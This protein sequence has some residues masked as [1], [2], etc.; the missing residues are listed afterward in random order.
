MPANCLRAQ[1]ISIISDFSH[2]WDVKLDF[3][4]SWVWT[5]GDPTPLKSV[6]FPRSLGER[7]LGA[8]IRYKNTGKLGLL[9]NRLDECLRRIQKVE[10]LPISQLTKAHL[11]QGS[12]Y[13]TGFYGSEVSYIGANHF[14]RL[15]TAASASIF[16]SLPQC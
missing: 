16:S 3:N 11:I 15:R 5:S 13:S 9:S 14:K 7:D 4:K 6:P 2:A 1:G 10:S 12:A 8:F